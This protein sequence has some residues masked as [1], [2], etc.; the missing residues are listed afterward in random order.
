VVFIFYFEVIEFL[1]F[2]I[3]KFLVKMLPGKKRP[4]FCICLS[5]HFLEKYSQKCLKEIKFCRQKLKI[6]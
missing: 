3:S 2:Y 6:V 5:F 1:M 4:N